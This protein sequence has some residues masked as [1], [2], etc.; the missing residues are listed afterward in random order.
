MRSRRS[1]F[2]LRSASSSKDDDDDDGEVEEAVAVAVAE[3]VAWVEVFCGSVGGGG[4]RVEGSA[5]T[6]EN[7]R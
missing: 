6:A 4:D 1:S 5:G 2:F 7:P 3:T